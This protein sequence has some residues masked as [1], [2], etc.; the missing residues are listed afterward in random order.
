MRSH[1]SLVSY[2]SVLLLVTGCLGL[3]ACGGSGGDDASTTEAR[4][5]QQVEEGA[6]EPEETEAEQPQEDT[7]LPE[8]DNNPPE[9]DP[10]EGQANDFPR[11]APPYEPGVYGIWQ[12]V[13]LEG[14]KCGNGSQYKF[15][16]NLTDPLFNPSGNIAIS[17]EPGGACWDYPSCTGETGIRGAANPN[18]VADDHMTNGVMQFMTPFTF[19]LH[20]V[21][22]VPTRFWHRVFFPYCTGDVFGG[23]NVT[24]YQ[25]P[26]GEEPDLEWHHVGYRNIQ[27]AAQWLAQEFDQTIPKMLVTGCSAGGAGSLINYHTLRQALDVEQGFMLNDSGPIYPADEPT[28]N[29]YPLHQKIA[30]AWNVDVIFDELEDELLAFG[31]RRSDF[32]TANVAIANRYPEDRLV[33]TQFSMDA[34]YSYYSYERFYEPKPDREE[35]HRRWQED[36]QALVALYDQYD[37]LAYFIPFY[38]N[39]NNSHCSTVV[40]FLD[41]DIQ[42]EGVNLGQ[43]LQ[44]MLNA[45]QPLQSYYEGLNYDDFEKDTVFWDVITLLRENL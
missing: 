6:D 30:E 5:N 20:P 32:G 44:T 27:K 39:F 2:W 23:S 21:E 4:A 35:I 14:T 8:E 25:D 24:V 11:P 42:A 41:T 10:D 36:E 17:F 12:K 38:R 9:S 37:N 26:E 19:A 45:E 1:T 22:N 40:T 29:S 18:G 13:E 16:V 34:D 7:E 3:T 33:H 28:D 43:Y 15:F 31:L